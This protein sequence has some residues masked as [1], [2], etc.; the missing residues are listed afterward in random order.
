M[1]IDYDVDDWVMLKNTEHEREYISHGVPHT[2]YGF[3][4]EH[5]IQVVVLDGISDNYPADIFEKYKIYKIGS[6]VQRISD[7]KLFI[8]R[9]MTEFKL[10]I[11]SKDNHEGTWV[12]K[13]DFLPKLMS[14]KYPSGTIVVHEKERYV[15]LYSYF[16]N[17]NKQEHIGVVKAGC[18]LDSSNYNVITL[19]A[20]K[21]TKDNFGYHTKHIDKGILGEFSKI[22][23]E[24][25]EMEDAIE[26]N[27]KIMV[28]NELTDIYG[29]IESYLEKHHPDISMN[30]LSVMS[31]ATKN[32]F[33]SGR[34]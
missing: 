16:S 24:V 13:S 28:L 30:D 11:H 27:N 26:Q 9:N 4:I 33:K 14:E 20:D 31:E 34:R 23:E 8:I 7:N 22:Y 12:N 18:E 19:P 15:V 6:Y 3:Y 17:L 32:A 29:A 21:V 5:G 25:L 2:V 10:K 1:S